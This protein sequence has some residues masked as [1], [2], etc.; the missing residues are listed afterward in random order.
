[1]NIVKTLK[2]E[3]EKGNKYITLDCEV[4]NEEKLTKLFQ[5][6]YLAGV[7]AGDIDMTEITFSEYC[8]M[9]FNDIMLVEDLIEYVIPYR[10]TESSDPTHAE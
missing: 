1:M 6:N 10:K 4:L 5:K 3:L 9:Q 2:K 8:E 7:K